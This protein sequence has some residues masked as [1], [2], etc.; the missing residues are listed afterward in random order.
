[1]LVIVI[2]ILAIVN[3]FAL[4]NIQ[5]YYATL[6]QN[7][8]I[9]SSKALGVYSAVENAAMAAGPVVFSYIASENTAPRMKILAGSLQGG[10]FLF[11]LIS[12][13]CGGK[14]SS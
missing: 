7:A 8:G 6:Y 12:G 11:A 4:T 2:L 10:L 1:M 3:I 13:I 14:H 5:T 9:S